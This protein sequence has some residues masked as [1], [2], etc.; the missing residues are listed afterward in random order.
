MNL[1][2]S[3]WLSV[4]IDV[5]LIYPMLIARLGSCDWWLSIMK[6]KWKGPSSHHR[7]RKLSIRIK[8]DDLLSHHTTS[9]NYCI[10]D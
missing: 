1:T 9:F 5:K 8:Q 2:L 6:L 3:Q 10:Y 7:E 4:A